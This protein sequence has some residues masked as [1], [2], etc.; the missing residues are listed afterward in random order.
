MISITNLIVMDPDRTA[1]DALMQ[2]STSRLGKV[3]VCDKE[4]KLIGLVSKTDIINIAGERQQYLETIRH[5]QN[6]D[7]RSNNNT[8]GYGEKENQ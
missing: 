3:F 1:D 6:N 8:I 5:L 7:K 2:M 4:G